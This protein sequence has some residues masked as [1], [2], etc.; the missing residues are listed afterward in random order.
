MTSPS[1]ASG[2]PK[3]LAIAGKAGWM[4]FTPITSAMLVA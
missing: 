3:G 1:A 4:K 2:M